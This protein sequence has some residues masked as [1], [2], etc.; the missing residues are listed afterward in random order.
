MSE[1]V[2]DKRSSER[3]EHD[4]QVAAEPSLLPLDL[5]TDAVSSPVEAHLSQHSIP[6]GVVGVV[7][8]ASDVVISILRKSLQAAMDHLKRHA[9]MVN[10]ES[11][12]NINES[13]FRFFVVAE[14]MRQAPHAKCQT[15]WN[16]YDLAVTID[17]ESLIVEFK[18]YFGFSRTYDL[19][20]AVP[21]R[22]KGGPSPQNRREF[23]ACLD[24]LRNPPKPINATIAGKYLVLV[25]DPGPW[26]GHN[27]S[28]V[29]SYDNL[30]TFGIATNEVEE[31]DHCYK[32]RAVCKLITVV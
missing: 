5:P 3:R 21:G 13:V 24:K 14:I 28:Y 23:R 7:Q 8:K 29:N 15:E 11:V 16:K 27:D 4:E 1:S 32:D 26:A 20:D 18:F 2:P 19:T 6:L 25:Y 9:E 10:W 31:I 22:W 17:K 12:N 30:E